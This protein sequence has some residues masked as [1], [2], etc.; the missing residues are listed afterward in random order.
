MLKKNK[1]KF[2]RV[3]VTNSSYFFM[4]GDF[5]KSDSMECWVDNISL[6]GIS[7]DVNI[8]SKIQIDDVIFISYKLGDELRKDKVQVKHLF[9]VINNTRCGCVFLNDDKER[10]DLIS[11]YIKYVYMSYND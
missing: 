11:S 5:L 6:G 3:D 7:I 10:S 1:R 9:R 4:M 2:D 8:K